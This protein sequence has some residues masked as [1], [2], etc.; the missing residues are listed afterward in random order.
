MHTLAQVNDTGVVMGVK[1]TKRDE[2]GLRA[3]FLEDQ[4]NSGLVS[5]CTSGITYMGQLF[6][7]EGSSS[8]FNQDI[9]GWN[10]SSIIDMSMMFKSA[11][12]FNQDLSL[13]CVANIPSIPTDF[14][15]GAGFENNATLM[16]HWNEACYV[17]KARDFWQ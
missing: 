4:N 11:S 9:G 5:S 6:H 10:T 14:A 2:A 7:V 8:T 13:W 1:Y 12:A 15:T 16:P 3:L 17:Y